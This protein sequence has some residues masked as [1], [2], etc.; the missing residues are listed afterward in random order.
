MVTIISLHRKGKCI[1]EDN[2]NYQGK[3]MTKEQ[4][5]NYRKQFKGKHFSPE[6]EFTSESTLGS[7]NPAARKVMCV[8][9]GM[10][11]EC[12]KDA[13]VFLGFRPEETRGKSCIS[14]ACKG[15]QKTAYGYH[16]KYIDNV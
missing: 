12:M 16:W 2:P 10:E 14:D 4:I 8:E 9:T 13:Y 7:K 3:S 5:E 15:K 1:G 11:F 6:T